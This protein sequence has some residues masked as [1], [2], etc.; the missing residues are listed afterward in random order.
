MDYQGPDKARCAWFWGQHPKALGGSL[1]QLPRTLFDSQGVKRLVASASCR[2]GRLAAVLP[3][4]KI[5]SKPRF[6]DEARQL[7]SEDMSIS[8]EQVKNALQSVKYPGSHEICSS[9]VKI[10]PDRE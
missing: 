5:R 9:G 10:G 8:E 2:R 1:R 4:N 6:T 7:I 3:E